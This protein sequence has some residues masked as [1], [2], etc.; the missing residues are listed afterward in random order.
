MGDVIETEEFSWNQEGDFN[1]WIA[2]LN[3]EGWF[4]DADVP[5]RESPTGDL[6]YTFIRPN[7][8]KAHAEP[9]LSA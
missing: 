8:A 7:Y 5:H 6:I 1:A 3:A 4:L 2:G 9:P